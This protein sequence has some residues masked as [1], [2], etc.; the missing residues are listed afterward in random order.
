MARAP[1]CNR[2]TD[3]TPERWQ[4]VKEIFD[5]AVERD[6]ASRL[7][8]IRERCGDDEELRRE[9]ESLLASDTRTGSLLYNP[10]IAE[11]QIPPDP[12]SLTG[13]LIGPYQ[14]LQELGRG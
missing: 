1:T 5:Q 8:Y 2:E 13:R 7:A 9:A 6:P 11:R 14:L 12:R 10:P 3:M 4:R